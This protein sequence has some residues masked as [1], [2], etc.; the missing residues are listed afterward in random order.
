MI[1]IRIN[2]IHYS[3]EIKSQNIYKHKKDLRKKRIFETIK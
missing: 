2:T 1:E 3:K